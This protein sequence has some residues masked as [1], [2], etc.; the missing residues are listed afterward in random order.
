VTG[1]AEAT[2]SGTA[3]STTRV[4]SQ[5]TTTA[6]QSIGASATSEPLPNFGP[7]ISASGT[8]SAKNVAGKVEF[9]GTGRWIGLVAGM[10]GLWIVPMMI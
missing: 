9:G 3:S 4:A 2:G 8:S 7:T 6:G 1:T 10:M 5:S